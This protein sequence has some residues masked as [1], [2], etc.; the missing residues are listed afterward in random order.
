MHSASYYLKEN[1]HKMPGKMGEKV[2]KAAP[3]KPG[4]RKRALNFVDDEA[5]EDCAVVQKVIK[6]VKKHSPNTNALKVRLL[7]AHYDVQNQEEVIAIEDDEDENGV[8]GA[9]EVKAVQNMK[10]VAEEEEEDEEDEEEEETVSDYFPIKPL[11]AKTRRQPTKQQQQRQHHLQNYK[12]ARNAPRD[13]AVPEVENIAAQIMAEYNAEYNP[14]TS[15]S[16]Q[17]IAENIGSQVNAP[18]S[19]TPPRPVSSQSTTEEEQVVKTPEQVRKEAL[20]LFR[21]I[22]TSSTSSAGSSGRDGGRMGRK[23]LSRQQ[24]QELSQGKAFHIL[25]QLLSFFFTLFLTLTKYNFSCLHF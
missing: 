18:S 22:S 9:A 6:K 11:M 4:R 25:L 21:Q 1:T 20:Q 15:S 2:A 5:E 23:S 12:N 10:A 3:K 16:V 17:P 7:G 13:K 19:T 14:P 8:H 24:S